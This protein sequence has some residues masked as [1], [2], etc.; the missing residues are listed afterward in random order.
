MDQHNLELQTRAWGGGRRNHTQTQERGMGGEE[1]SKC[2]SLFGRKKKSLGN[3]GT[4]QQQE[5]WVLPLDVLGEPLD[6]EPV[7]FLA[8]LCPPMG[9]VCGSLW[10]ENITLSFPKERDGAVWGVGDLHGGDKGLQQVRHPIAMR[11]KHDVLARVGLHQ[12]LRGRVESPHHVGMCLR[13]ICCRKREGFSNWHGVNSK[14][15]ERASTW[16][17]RYM[18]G[19]VAR[20]ELCY[21]LLGLIYWGLLIALI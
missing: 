7:V 2:G 18:G 6:V 15:R 14:N 10:G 20:N 16:S 9:R 4:T 13:V 21:L 17:D 12:L 5:R 8:L 3:A 19:V 1:E 11:H